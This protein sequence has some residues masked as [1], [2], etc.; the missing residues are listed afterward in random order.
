MSYCLTPLPWSARK[1]IH[2]LLEGL[3]RVDYVRRHGSTPSAQAFSAFHLMAEEDDYEPDNDTGM[4][5]S[6][7]AVRLCGA[8]CSC[9]ALGQPHCGHKHFRLHTVES[10]APCADCRLG[11][12]CRLGG[13]CVNLHTYFRRDYITL[14][15]YD[16]TRPMTADEWMGSIRDSA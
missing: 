10:R 4:L 9:A 7:I 15:T 12:S 6:T 11:G 13:A 3:D 16:S 1:A 14:I 5:L 8:F 2:G